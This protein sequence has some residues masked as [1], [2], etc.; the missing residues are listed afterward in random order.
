MDINVDVLFLRSYISRGVGGGGRVTDKILFNR[1]LNPTQS[2][3][4]TLSDQG[5]YTPYLSV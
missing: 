1:Y 2:Y 4:Y 3:I 5:V